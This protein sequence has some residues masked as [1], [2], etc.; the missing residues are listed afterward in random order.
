MLHIYELLLFQKAG[1]CNY[2]LFGVLVHLGGSMGS[3]HYFCFVK[4]SNQLWH[5]MDDDS[6]SD[7]EGGEGEG[8]G[9]E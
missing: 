2:T 1:S 5:E 3:G 4:N 6:V 7:G 8:M 9:R